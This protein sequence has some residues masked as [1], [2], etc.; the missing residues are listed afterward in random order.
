MQGKE[1]MLIGTEVI[2]GLE[3][4]I[5][6]DQDQIRY[7]DGDWIQ[8][9]KN[10]LNVMMLPEAPP[11]V[12]IPETIVGILKQ[13]GING[14]EEDEGSTSTE[15]EHDIGYLDYSSRGKGTKPIAKA[16]QSDPQ[17]TDKT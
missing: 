15:S 10:S 1:Q 8:T 3:M 14:M 2:S 16:Y 4:V 5:D 9:A 12:R 7:G 17:N 6:M 11:G 13:R